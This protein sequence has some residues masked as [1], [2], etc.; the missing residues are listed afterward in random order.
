MEMPGH[1]AIAVPMNTCTHV[2]AL[3]RQ[4]AADAIDTGLGT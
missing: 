1:P 3:L 4:D 2:L